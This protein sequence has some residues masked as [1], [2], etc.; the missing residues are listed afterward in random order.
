MFAEKII[1]QSEDAKIV[2][3]D[4]FDTLVSRLWARPVDLFYCLEQ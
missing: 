2:S 3:F 1:T 4:I